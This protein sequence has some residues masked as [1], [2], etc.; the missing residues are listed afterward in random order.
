MANAKSI[1]L[2][3]DKE[4]KSLVSQQ[5]QGRGE[6]QPVSSHKP[7]SDEQKV[8]ILSAYKEKGN[9]IETTLPERDSLASSRSLVEPT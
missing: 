7:D 9:L 6:L 1:E 5:G 2:P 8:P 3:P 4:S